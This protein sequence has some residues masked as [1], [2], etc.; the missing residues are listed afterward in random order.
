MIPL[1][2]SARIDEDHQWSSEVALSISWYI[3]RDGKQHGP[4]SE[5]EFAEVVK[6][7]FLLPSD[8][9]WCEGLND[10]LQAKDILLATQD[11]RPEELV[12]AAKEEESSRNLEPANPKPSKRWVTGPRM[13]VG[14]IAMLSVFVA[15]LSRSNNASALGQARKNP[16]RAQHVRANIPIADQARGAPH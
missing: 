14:L 6:Q 8:H 15:W 16:T 12:V 10:W 5:I 13:F 3:A 4:I 2:G 9:V 1:L 7:G 11:H